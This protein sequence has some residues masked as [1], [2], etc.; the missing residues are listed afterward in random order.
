MK[1]KIKNFLG[2]SLFTILFFGITF[3]LYTFVGSSI[4]ALF[5]VKFTST[6]Y[7]FFFMLLFCILSTVIELFTDAFVTILT[8]FRNP[9]KKSE[10]I[11][12][13][14]V[15]VSTKTILFLICDM[16]I[17]NV[18]LSFISP[19]LTSFI[20]FLIEYKIESSFGN[21]QNNEGKNNLDDA[22]D[23]MEKELKNFEKELKKNTDK[24]K[25]DKKEK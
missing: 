21:E 19:I 5:G 22:I 18:T 24:D 10:F 12:K 13:L 3:V 17:E 20:L 8:E 2:I 4:F 23:D 14:F 7:L 11:L 6:K 1:S 16:L 15:S 9:N 25:D